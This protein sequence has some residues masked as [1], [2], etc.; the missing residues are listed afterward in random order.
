MD[1]HKVV[2]KLSIGL[3]GHFSTDLWIKEK[4]TFPQGK[5]CSVDGRIGVSI[6]Y[7]DGTDFLYDQFR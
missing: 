3:Y 2:F 7:D 4:Q 5:V 6:P 1:I